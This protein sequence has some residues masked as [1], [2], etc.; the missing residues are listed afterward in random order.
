[1]KED[2]SAALGKSSTLQA[3]NILS[4]FTD[5]GDV[6]NPRRTVENVFGGSLV[7]A[8]FEMVAHVDDG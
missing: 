2:S 4:S 3:A 6:G 1:M 7:L 5:W 8:D